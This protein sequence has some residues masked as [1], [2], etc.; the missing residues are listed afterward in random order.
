M[1]VWGEKEIG[2]FCGNDIMYRLISSK[3]YVVKSCESGLRLREWLV[4]LEE[5]LSHSQYS[6][7]RVMD[8]W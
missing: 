7:Y 8:V 2:G 3:I 6:P 1:I 5:Y 4:L